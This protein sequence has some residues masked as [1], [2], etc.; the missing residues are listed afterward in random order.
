MLATHTVSVRLLDM[1]AVAGRAAGV[2]VER[3]FVEV[4]MSPHS[5]DHPDARV[6]LSVHEAAWQAVGDA[7]GDPLF[8]LAAAA[9]MQTEQL[10]AFG[11]TISNSPTFGQALLAV[12]RYNRLMHDVAEIS[13]ERTGDVVRVVHRFQGTLTPPVWPASLVTV[14]SLVGVGRHLV[15]R[16]WTPLSVWFPH[17]PPPDVRP[18][19]MFL[20]VDPVFDQP[21][22]GL[23]LSAHL[24]D[25]PIPGAD[26]GLHALL[27][28]HADHLLEQMPAVSASFTDRTR[29]ALA[30][31]MPHGFVDAASVAKDLAVSKRTLQRRLADEGR[32]LQ[33]LLDGLREEM[34]KVLLRR[35]ELSVSEVAFLLGYSE[36]SPFQRAFKRWTGKTPGSFRTS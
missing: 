17:P 32:S 2:D 12:S 15:Q 5:L 24:L 27:R 10:D 8:G 36:P 28:R 29:D 6:S 31:G 20:G 4:G 3:V 9:A 11:Y 22:G 23:T 14:A 34:A 21:D 19:A 16:P 13:V 25:L 18:L 30:R 35:P 26:P 1:L 33:E 7:S